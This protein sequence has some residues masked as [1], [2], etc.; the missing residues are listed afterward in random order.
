MARRTS[1]GRAGPKGASDA[2]R[3]WRGI[4]RAVRTAGLALL[5]AA[6]GAGA[7]DPPGD[8]GADAAPDAL[9]RLRHRMVATQ[10]EA[11]GLRDPRVLDALRRVPRHRFAPDVDPEDAYADHPHPIGLGQTIS[12]PYIVALM[13]DLAEIDPPCRVLEVGTGS[14][15]QAAVLAEMG[16]EVWSIEI[17]PTLAERAREVLAAEGYG[18]RVRVRIGDGYRGWPEEAPFDAILVTAAAPRVPEPLLEQ[19]RVGARLVVPVGEPWQMLEVHERTK[20]GIERSADTAVRFVPM[21]GEIRG[22]RER[23]D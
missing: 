23:A 10:V 2:G 8:A 17:V 7:S 16:C 12:Q 14:G 4:A 11:R 21:T 18:E 13:S 22:G 9:T 20:T 6:C 19:L 15:Y 3:G 1:A 5:G